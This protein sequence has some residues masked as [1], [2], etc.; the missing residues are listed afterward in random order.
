M[1]L[2]AL[3]S[4]TQCA[5]CGERYGAKQTHTEAQMDYHGPKLCLRAAEI[6]HDDEHQCRT[7]LICGHRWP[8][9]CY[10]PEQPELPT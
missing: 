7:C 1:T 2:P 10:V 8:E 6:G 3:H 9:A 4:V 5:K